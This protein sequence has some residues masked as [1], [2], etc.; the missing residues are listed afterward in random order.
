LANA[1]ALPHV[2]RFNAPEAAGPYAELARAMGFSTSTDDAAATEALAAGVFELTRACGLPVRYRDAGV[3]EA[4][5]PAIAEAAISD[6]SIVYNPRMAMDP[7]LVLEVL[8]NA[9]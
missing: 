8:R 2:I 1:I 7:A 3:P 9:W 5:L 6:A 4:D